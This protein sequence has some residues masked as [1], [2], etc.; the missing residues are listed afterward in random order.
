MHPTLALDHI[1]LLVH[2]DGVALDAVE[3]L[4]DH[5]RLEEEALIRDEE[6][7]GVPLLDHCWKVIVA[8]EDRQLSVLHHRVKLADAVVGEL[9]RRILMLSKHTTLT[10][11]LIY[12]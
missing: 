7:E 9:T 11:Q 2:E 12:L 1:E 5:V 3:S 8:E 10:S 4:P 6:V